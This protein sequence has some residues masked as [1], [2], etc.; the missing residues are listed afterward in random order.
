MSL[1]IDAVTI[2]LGGRI[3]LDNVSLAAGP[4]ELIFLLGPNG[5]GKTTLLRA[6]AALITHDGRISFA[7]EALGG[8]PA[9]LRARKLAYLPQGHLAHWPL[10]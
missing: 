5:S 7:G 3:I 2:R 10:T 9:R 1:E 4:G 8:L 6:I